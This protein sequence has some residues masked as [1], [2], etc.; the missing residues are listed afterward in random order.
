MMETVAVTL[1]L[2]ADLYAELQAQAAEEQ[3]DPADLIAR[4][5]AEAH[6]Y[7][8]TL[9][10][11]DPVLDLIGAYHSAKPLIDGIPASEDP[12]LYVIAE[13]MGQQATKM[14]AWD[15]APQR[16]VQGPHGRALRRQPDT[17]RP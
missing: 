6:H 16:Y 9:P 11:R 4:V 2:P 7:R 5:V 13:Q 3:T 10:E 15:L 1:H 17:A 8:A 14:H 12:D